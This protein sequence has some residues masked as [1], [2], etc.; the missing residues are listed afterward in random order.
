VLGIITRHPVQEED[1]LEAMGD[2]SAEEIRG[3]LFELEASGQA[4][5]VERHGHQFWTPTLANFP[6]DAQSWRTAPKR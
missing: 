6:D 5:I 2:W 1:L 3:V 4:K